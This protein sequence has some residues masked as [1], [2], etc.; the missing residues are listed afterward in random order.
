MKYAG[1]M[2]SS[3]MVYR[4]SKVK[5]HRQHGD[6][7]S[8][9]SES[10]LKTACSSKTSMTSIDR[11]SQ[12]NLEDDNGTLKCLWIVLEPF[13]QPVGGWSE[14]QRFTQDTVCTC[15]HK[16]RRRIALSHGGLRQLN[17]LTTI[18]QTFKQDTEGQGVSM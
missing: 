11:S 3:V 7:I 13:H 1:E 5:T 6:R 10:R 12:I 2:G 15:T 4:H 8:I 9:L 18:L 14:T 17:R 16:V